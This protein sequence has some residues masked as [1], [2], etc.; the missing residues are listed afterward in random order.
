MVIFQ[1]LKI[2]EATSFLFVQSSSSPWSVGCSCDTA[3]SEADD[4]RRTSLRPTCPSRGRHGLL[5]HLLAIPRAEAELAIRGMAMAQTELLLLVE[6]S[7]TREM[8]G[9]T[10]MIGLQEEAT[11]ITETRESQEGE[12]RV[13]SFGPSGLC[14]RIKSILGMLCGHHSSQRSRPHCSAEYMR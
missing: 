9:M 3:D 8:E 12:S 2:S 7:V 1:D 5:A 11:G 14:A 10:E 4:L 13:P 6:M